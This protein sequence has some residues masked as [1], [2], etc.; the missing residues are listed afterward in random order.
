[1]SNGNDNDEPGSLLGNE[2]PRGRVEDARPLDRS[3]YD[4]NLSENV[5]DADLPVQ[6]QAL[7]NSGM[8]RLSWSLNPGTQYTEVSLKRDG[9]VIAVFDSD[10]DHYDLP[11]DMVTGSTFTVDATVSGADPGGDAEQREYNRHRTM[12]WE[13]F[14]DWFVE[15][16]NGSPFRRWYDSYYKGKSG[17]EHLTWWPG[18]GTPNEKFPFE[19][20]EDMKPL[21]KLAGLN[22]P[23]EHG[24]DGDNA[25]DI[26][27]EKL[28]FG[29]KAFDLTQEAFGAARGCY[30]V[31]TD[32]FVDITDAFRGGYQNG[33]MRWIFKTPRNDE[34]KFVGSL[35]ELL[36]GLKNGWAWTAIQGTKEFQCATLGG[37]EFGRLIDVGSYIDYRGDWSAH[38]PSDPDGNGGTLGDDPA[39]QWRDPDTKDEKI[40]VA[41]RFGNWE[42]FGIVDKT[43]TGPLVEGSED[44]EKPRFETKDDP[45]F[46]DGKYNVGT[47]HGI[48]SETKIGYDAPG[49]A[50]VVYTKE[51]KTN[52]RIWSKTTVT[53]YVAEE[54]IKDSCIWSQVS[55][56]STISVTDH[57]N[58]AAHPGEI[59][60]QV[61]NG[62]YSRI[63][64]LTSVAMHTVL[65]GD[66]HEQCYGH[67]TDF[68][69]GTS[70][71]LAIGGVTNFELAG[72]FELVVAL[73][74]E[75]FVG[76]LLSVFIG[77]KIDVELAGTKEIGTNKTTVEA[78]IKTLA[79]KHNM[80][81]SASQHIGIGVKYTAL[82]VDL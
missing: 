73:A 28:T 27:E 67:K 30:E 71:S 1:M 22:V 57:I 13:L 53:G 16:D 70:H 36:Y 68:L 74:T 43:Y 64:K 19:D 34:I 11:S 21:P 49:D 55:A 45:G 72:K 7:G 39:T 33:D 76:G 2:D 62:S 78:D 23:P 6:Q 52:K 61:V 5:V 3:F 24:D 77:G 82:K 65:N 63:E 66:D 20:C 15:D 54:E 50:N 79:A 9:A 60:S 32:V 31:W 48:L 46:T 26:D 12:F 8:H 69:L 35:T 4:R 29:H 51:H 56:G 40:N 58:T 44:D 42:N 17:K 38:N 59:W 47:H 75:I 80:L 25:P 10:V 81:A 18:Y 14:A 41:H 37:Y